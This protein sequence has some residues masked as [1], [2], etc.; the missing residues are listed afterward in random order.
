MIDYTFPCKIFYECVLYRQTRQ[1]ATARDGEKGYSNVKFWLN[2]R[3][4]FSATSNSTE[5]EYIL[6]HKHIRISTAQPQ[7]S[8]AS[9]FAN[10]RNWWAANTFTS[11]VFSAVVVTFFCHSISRRC[12]IIRWLSVRNAYVLSLTVASSGAWN[13]YFIKS[14]SYLIQYRFVLNGILIKK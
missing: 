3:T 13:F 7:T 5:L 1:R 2:L 11:C 6:D 4:Y 10:W 14:F 12:A 8:A 9:N